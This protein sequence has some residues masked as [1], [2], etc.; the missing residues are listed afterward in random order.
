MY[1][2]PFLST[3]KRA[4]SSPSI[5]RLET[6]GG[7]PE[8]WK[9]RL[10]DG[11][12]RQ[13]TRCGAKEAQESPDGRSLYVTRQH[14]PG[15]WRVALEGNGQPTRIL[16]DVAWQAWMSSDR[17]IYSYEATSAEP[18]IYFRESVVGEPVLVLPLPA[19]KLGFSVSKDHRWLS[20]AQIAPRDGDIILIE[21]EDSV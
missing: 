17:G 1:P 15:L 21:A 11:D 16:D 20:Y 5:Y 3:W 7:S 4:V 8:V 6:T 2:S 12:R 13:V 18:G 10:D 14:T 19:V 9:V